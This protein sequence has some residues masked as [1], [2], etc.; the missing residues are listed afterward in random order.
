MGS[1]PLFKHRR[2]RCFLQSFNTH[3]GMTR[4]PAR[5]NM[6]LSWL[7]EVLRASWAGE[8]PPKAWCHDSGPLWMPLRKLRTAHDVS[9]ITHGAVMQTHTHT[10]TQT[11]ARLDRSAP[12]SLSLNTFIHFQN[13]TNKQQFV[14][15]RHLWVSVG[16]LF[17][18]I[19]KYLIYAH[20]WLL[21]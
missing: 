12:L 11:T 10:Y 13:R 4:R 5:K 8:L 16:L 2:T 18:P 15:Q 20:L 7:G 3:E 19:V 17:E 14:L 21:I 6:S 9:Q 1:S